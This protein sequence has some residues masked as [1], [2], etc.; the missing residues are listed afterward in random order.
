M[1]ERERYYYKIQNLVKMLLQNVK[2]I[3]NKIYTEHN[4]DHNIHNSIST[5][6]RRVSV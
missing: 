2:K 4:T 1:L 6:D 3:Q 5:Y